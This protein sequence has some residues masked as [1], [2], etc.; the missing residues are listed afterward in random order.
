M[1]AICRRVD[2]VPRSGQQGQ[3]CWMEAV[4]PVL[5]RTVWCLF[6]RLG[7]SITCL[8]RDRLWSV[9]KFIL[10]RFLITRHDI[11]HSVPD[12]FASFL[13]S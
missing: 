4:P 8:H 5:I 12:Q 10:I 3:Q 11:E 2:S 1:G 13:L 9:M 6:P 7:T